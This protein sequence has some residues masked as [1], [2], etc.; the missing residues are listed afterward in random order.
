MNSNLAG[1]LPEIV[2]MVVQGRGVKS[3]NANKI[4]TDSSRR[5]MAKA[6]E[7]ASPTSFI[8]KK[9]KQTKKKPLSIYLMPDTSAIL[10][11]FVR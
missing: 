1:V 5:F 4:S 8:H 2:K 7:S 10:R 9:Q 6:N 11:P 3:C